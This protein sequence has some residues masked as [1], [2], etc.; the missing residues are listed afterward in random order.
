MNHTDRTPTILLVEDNPTLS[1]AVREALEHEGYQVFQAPDGRTALELM[2][3]HSP[4]LVLQDLLLPD[5]DGV[6]L[7]PQI[8]SFPGGMSVPVVAVS[9]FP[10]MIEAARRLEHGFDSFLVKPFKMPDVLAE[11]RRFFPFGSAP[12]SP[13]ISSATII[14]P[15]PQDGP[16]LVHPEPD[17]LDLVPL[18]LENRRRDLTALGHAI[19]EGDLW[20]IQTLGHTMKGDGGAFG[21]V[22]ISEI[23]A[24]LEE[25]GK[26]KDSEAAR[27]EVNG[28]ADYL[29]RVHVADGL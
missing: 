1:W 10:S 15:T 2:S 9:G 5:M 7:L 25:A 19:E 26:A 29:A 28:L 24:R 14:A 12:H 8:R 16:I 3:S 17:L 27:R 21:F 23:G 6:D 18:F 4:G 11:C 22:G 20:T 13:A